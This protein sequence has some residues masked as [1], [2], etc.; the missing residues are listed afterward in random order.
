MVALLGVELSKQKSVKMS[1][2]VWL[3]FRLRSFGGCSRGLTMEGEG[4]E[5]RESRQRRDANAVGGKEIFGYR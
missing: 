1:S 2:A 3:A 5:E 4:R